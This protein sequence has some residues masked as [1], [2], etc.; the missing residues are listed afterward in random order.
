MYLAALQLRNFRNYPELAL[1]FSP[2]LN[3]VF[4]NNAQGKTNL[5]EAVY[6]LATGKSHRAGRDQELICHGAQELRVRARVTRQTGTLDLE[7]LFSHETRKSLKIN[8]IPEKRIA[9]LVGK[10]AVVFF[11]P[12]DLMLVKGPPAGRRRFLDIELSQVSSTYLHHLQ[13]YT[14]VLTQRNSLL[15]QI[16]DGQGNPRLLDI[17]DEQLLDAGSQLVARRVRAVERLA[18]LAAQYHRTLTEGKEELVL[19]Y[20]STAASTADGRFPAPPAPGEVRERLAALLKKR[21][22]EE[23]A[24][25]T[26]VVGPHR[27]DLAVVINRLDARQYGSQGQQRTA[28]LSLKLAELYFMR[29]EIG[30]FPVLLLDDVASELDPTRRHYLVNAFENGIQTLVSCTDLEDLAARSW[31]ADHR[32]FRVESGRVTVEQGGLR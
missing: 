18:A 7:L 14:K 25:A 30:E 23:L 6:V 9:T 3:V 4:G 8:G 5:L 20:S 29:E 2:G 13:V 21:R 27:D 28:V 26:T 11:S 19:Y 24:R 15:R 16:A 32:V 10:L 31:P 12:D 17:L 22:H 1:E